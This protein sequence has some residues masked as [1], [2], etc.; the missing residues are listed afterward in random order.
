MMATR[1]ERPYSA[2]PH[3]ESARPLNTS[4]PVSRILTRS[5]SQSTAEARRSIAKTQAFEDSAKSHSSPS[6]TPR[7]KQ[8]HAQPEAVPLRRMNV[9]SGA[10]ATL[11][12]VIFLLF[13]QILVAA[14]LCVSLHSSK[15]ISAQ[16]AEQGKTSTL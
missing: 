7:L 8:Q 3:L 1:P 6:R 9:I 16:I 12:T 5:Q 15:Q 13:W 2:R 10:F 14:V 4:P 11:L